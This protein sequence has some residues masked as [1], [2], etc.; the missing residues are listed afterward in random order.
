TVAPL[1]VVSYPF[2]P[3]KLPGIFFPSSWWN[4]GLLYSWRQRGLLYLG[5]RSKTFAALGYLDGNYVVFSS[6]FDVISQV[7]GPRAPWDRTK[8]TGEIQNIPRG[9]FNIATAQMDIYNRHQRIVT[10]AFNQDL[11]RRVWQE[12]AIVFREMSGEEGW[13]NTDIVRLGDIKTITGKFTLSIIGRAGFGISGDADTRKVIGSDGLSLR[14][15]F[16][17]TGENP[18]IRTMMPSWMFKLPIEKLHRVKSAN[19]LLMSTMH[20]QI[21]ARQAENAGMA[22][23]ARRRDIFHYLMAANDLEESD[24]ALTDEELL[25]NTFILL[26]AGHETSV[27][28]LAYTIALLACYPEEQDRLSRFVQTTLGSKDAAVCKEYSLLDGA[29]RS[30]QDFEHLILCPAVAPVVMRRSTEDSLL[31]V[32]E[33][34]KPVHLPKGTLF[35]GDIIGICY[36]AE[37][38][39]DPHTFR[40]E[41]W[42][43]KHFT[44]EDYITFGHGVHMCLGRRFAMYE[45]VCFITMLVKTW[46]VRPEL[47]TGES[48]IQWRKKVVDDSV[49]MRIVLGPGDIPIRLERRV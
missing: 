26:F 27:R 25:S 2:A 49:R 39:P 3:F 22:S 43:G 13:D 9:A 23:D 46:T 31:K 4:P 21:S 37:R 1:P 47:T 34:S 44:N 32:P 40:P 28:V 20:K 12:S 35:V 38:F 15:A 6:S 30:S 41:R 33:I 7:S 10:P 36:D 14:E 48:L 24:K 42:A 5:N 16:R 8:K 11:Y 29:D 17:L 19:D 45:M 18:L